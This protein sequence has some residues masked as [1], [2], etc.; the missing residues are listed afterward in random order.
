M[1]LVGRDLGGYLVSIT[2][3]HEQMFV[4]AQ[5]SQNSHPD[6]KEKFFIGLSATVLPNGGLIYNWTSKEP[7]TF[8]AWGIDQPGK[9]FLYW[10]VREC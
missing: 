9:T 4:T 1:I 10:I 7:V 5:A 2:S 8:T 3:Y 6:D